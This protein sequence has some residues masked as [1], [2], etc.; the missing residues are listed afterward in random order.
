MIKS[1]SQRTSDDYSSE[2]L[3]ILLIYIYSV[4]GEFVLDKD[5]REAEDRVKKA[6]AHVF[7]EE[8]ELSPLLQKITGE[9]GARLQ[10]TNL[11]N[12]SQ[13]S[14]ERLVQEE[15]TISSQLQGQAVFP[16]FP[17]LVVVVE[18]SAKSLSE[19]MF[20]GVKALV[21]QKTIQRKFGL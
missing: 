6:L 11:G 10:N 12:R 14:E 9:C 18:W 8:S 7:S 21:K 1:P 16:W 3:L 13:G 19:F 20:V 4:T 2:E 17:F 15:E 5:L